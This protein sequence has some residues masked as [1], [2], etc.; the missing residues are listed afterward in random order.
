MFKK[1]DDALIFKNNSVKN[2]QI[3]VIFGTQDPNE[4]SHRMIINVSL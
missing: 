1:I 4:M 3:L 2:E